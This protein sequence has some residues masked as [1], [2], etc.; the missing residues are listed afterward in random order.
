MY[1]FLLKIFIKKAVKLTFIMTFIFTSLPDKEVTLDTQGHIQLTL[2]TPH[3]P[4]LSLPGRPT[5]AQAGAWT[6][7]TQGAVPWSPHGSAGVLSLQ[8]LSHSLKRKSHQTLTH[9]LCFIKVL[10]G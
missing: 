6:G 9:L 4:P 1:S 2:D 5:G 10:I 8:P 7:L 3:V